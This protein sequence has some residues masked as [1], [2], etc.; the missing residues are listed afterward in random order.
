MLRSF[1]PLNEL[2]GSVL[3][4]ARRAV[5]GRASPSP[6]PITHHPAQRQQSMPRC[7]SHRKRQSV[8]TRLCGTRD[9]GRAG[10]LPEQGKERALAPGGAR[11]VVTP[12]ST[13]AQGA[14]WGCL[15]LFI[16][17]KTFLFCMGQSLRVRFPSALKARHPFSSL[18]CHTRRGERSPI[19]PL[20]SHPKR[21]GGTHAAVVPGPVHH[22]LVVRSIPG[23]RE[24]GAAQPE[25]LSPPQP[26]RSP[27]LRR[28]AGLSPGAALPLGR[29]HSATAAL[30]RA[31]FAAPP[32]S[33]GCRTPAP[34]RSAA[35]PS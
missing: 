26:R 29:G 32:A 14:G 5:N 21:C 25:L 13:A 16:P 30:R 23:E 2:M 33:W 34:G 22:S 12:Q 3:S 11:A 9:G 15:L 20:R 1:P 7:T 19:P 18:F 24:G 17:S 28:T 6:L 10:G 31:P 8:R 35:R 27:L 4:P